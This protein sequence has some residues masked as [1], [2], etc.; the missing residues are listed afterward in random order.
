V[1]LNVMPDMFARPGG[2]RADL[3]HLVLPVQAI[4]CRFARVADW[5]RRSA[6][7]QTSAP[8]I[9]TR[10]G[11]TFRSR[12]H[13]SGSRFHSSAPYCASCWAGVSATPRRRSGCADSAP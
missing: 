4:T 5:L 1:L 12:Q 9:A 10:S 2:Q 6:V 11:S 7:S 13:R 8:C 3:E